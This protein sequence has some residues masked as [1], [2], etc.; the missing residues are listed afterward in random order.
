MDTMA[1][2]ASGDGGAYGRE[3]QFHDADLCEVG[4]GTPC[5][6][7][8]RRYWQPVAVSSKVTTRPRKVRV[9]GEDLILF[10]DGTGRPGLLYPRCAHRGTTLYYGKVDEKGIRC[11]Y[12]GW[13]FDVEGR[14]I[15]Q[16]CEPQGGIH[17][18]RVRQ[19]WYPVEDLY[20]LVFAYMGPAARK[21]LL[22]RWDILEDLGPDEKLFPNVTSGFTPFQDKD[23][24]ILECNWLQAWENVMDPFHVPI[25]HVSHSGRGGGFAPSLAIMPDVTFEHTELGTLYRAHR[26]MDDG[27]TM[28]RVS[29][30]MLP[31]VMSVPDGISTRPGRSNHM[32]WK[33]A[34]DDTHTA[35]FSVLRVPREF[36]G[37]PRFGTEKLWSEMTEE[38]H[39]RMPQD[40]EAQV[41]QGPITLHSEE[42]LATTDKGV[43]MLRR[44]L[45][46]EIRRVQAGEDPLGV[47]YD[48]RQPVNK[49]VS[50]NFYADAKATV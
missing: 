7:F 35:N 37:R 19:P 20:G 18:D 21:P 23:E 32:I 12:H 24:D 42:H 27:R 43:A 8:L 25:L 28:D 41:G 44:R 38:E 1:D 31:N 47:M 17:K 34:V 50:G 48:A 29:V 13:Q 10:R 33:V 46:E 15:D 40:H 26:K 9:L 22:P 16:P 49:V 4:P 30:A 45:R 2:T 11:C 3:K 14:C 6:E 5:G 39:Q 36:T